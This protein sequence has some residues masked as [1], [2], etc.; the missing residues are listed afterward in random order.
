MIRPDARK[1]IA[2]AILLLMAGCTVHPP[3]ERDERSAAD[4]L[5]KPFASRPENRIVPPLPDD[6]SPE[7]LVEYAL[8]NN[9]DLEQQFWQWRSAIE[10][11]PQDG[12]QTTNL[13]LSANVGISRGRTNFSQATLSAGND[14]MADIVLPPKLSVA[15]RRTL[16]TARAAGMR[17]RKSQLELRAKVLSAWYDYVLNAELIRLEQ[18]NGQLLKTTAMVVEARNRAG[19]AGQQDLLKARNEL[20]LS[21]NDVATMQ[22]QLPGQRAAMNALLS[23]PAD[24]A[25]PTPST[26]PPPST[27]DYSDAQVLA[28]A[29]ELNPELAAQSH[30]IASRKQSIALARLQ[31]LPDISLSGGTDLQ[32]IAQSVLGMVTVPFLRHEAIDAAVAQAEANLR[33]AESMRRQSRSDLNTQI[34][35]DLNTIRDA[36]RQIDL[37][38]HTILPRAEQTVTI[39]RSAYESGQSTLL[40]VLDAQRSL[41]S[42]RRLVVNLRAVREKRVAAI[43]AVFSPTR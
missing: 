13:V 12:T 19:A 8:Q 14:P 41:I 42:L 40:D 32:G 28:L 33:A 38:D 30:E 2:T 24:A 35:T 31:Y 18:A 37:I 1:V 20:D 10:Q 16:E 22:S 3:G 4:R 25:L 17:F 6:A 5:G 43:R 23:R 29:R 11:I 26:L 27:L 21:A 15:A 9:A 36:D 39:A 7:Q 34:V